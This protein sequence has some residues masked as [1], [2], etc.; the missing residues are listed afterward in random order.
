V[1]LVDRGDRDGLVRGLAQV[2][3]NE[4]LRQELRQ[5]SLHAATQYFSWDAIAASFGDAMAARPR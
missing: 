3:T 4:E 2:L 5:R 1:N